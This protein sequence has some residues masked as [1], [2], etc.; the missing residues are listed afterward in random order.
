MRT[1]FIAVAALIIGLAVGWSIHRN[2]DAQE[3]RRFRSLVGM[4][5]QQI[6]EL[7]QT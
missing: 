4:S 1:T 6:H 7:Y 2:R 5:D 3:I